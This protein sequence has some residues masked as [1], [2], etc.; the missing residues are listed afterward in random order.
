MIKVTRTSP[1]QDEYYLAPDAYDQEMCWHGQTISALG[2]EAGENVDP[3][4]F[5]AVYAGIHPDTGEQLIPDG[6]QSDYRGH[7]SGFDLTISPDK[8]VSVVGL[9]LD[10]PEVLDAFRAAVETTIDSAE[11]FAAGRK[12]IYGETEIEQTGNLA[13]VVIVHSTTRPVKTDV[14]VDS[15]E[16]SVDSISSSPPDPQLHAHNNIFNVTQRE[17]GKLV[18]LEPHA[19]FQAQ[20]E[21]DSVFNNQLA[22]NLSDLGYGIEKTESGAARIQGIPTEVLDQFS[23]RRQQILDKVEEMREAGYSIPD[24]SLLQLANLKTRAGKESSTMEDLQA[25]WNDQLQ[26]L[27]Y[28]R[29]QLQQDVMAAGKEQHKQRESEL[30]LSATDYVRFVG[31]QLANDNISFS[32]NEVLKAARESAFSRVGEK[33][34][35]AA[36][37]DLVQRKE[38]AEI[39]T[40]PGDS[41]YTT[42]QMYAKVE[43]VGDFIRQANR[44]VQINK[45]SLGIE[46]DGDL[47]VPGAGDISTDMTPTHL[48][49][50]RR[51]AERDRAI[52]RISYPVAEKTIVVGKIDLENAAK[53]FKKASDREIAQMLIAGDVS[54]DQIFKSTGATFNQIENIRQK[55]Y[56]RAVQ[57]A[58]R[59]LNS[60]INAAK[61][62]LT[63]HQ[64][65]LK[66]AE[67]TL[68]VHEHHSKPNW[69]LGVGPEKTVL[70]GAGY[71]TYKTDKTI[72]L[73]E[74]AG[75]RKISSYTTNGFVFTEKSKT[76]DVS[77]GKTYESKSHGFK[78]KLGSLTLFEMKTQNIKEKDREGNIIHKTTKTIT[79]FGTKY[80][81][82]SIK[83]KDGS[84]TEVKW[85]G[86]EKTDIFGR[87]KLV[88]KQQKSAHQPKRDGIF[89]TIMLA[90]MAESHIPSN[91]KTYQIADQIALAER[92]GRITRFGGKS[93]QAEVMQAIAEKATK[94]DYRSN[95]ILTYSKHRAETLNQ[96]IRNELVQSG[97]L[98]KGITVQVEHDTP[99][100]RVSKIIELAAGDH[101]RLGNKDKELGI[102]GGEVGIVKSIDSNGKLVMSVQNETEHN[103]I[104][105]NINRYKNITHNY[106]STS[107]HSKSNIHNIIVDYDAKY[108]NKNMFA[109]IEQSIKSGQRLYIVSRESDNNMNIIDVAQKYDALN[110]KYK[111]F[112]SLSKDHS[113]LVGKLAVLVQRSDDK[114]V[115]Y[116][117]AKVLDLDIEKSSAKL[118]YTDKRGNSVIRNHSLKDIMVA[119]RKNLIIPDAKKIEATIFK[120][121]IFDRKNGIGKSIQDKN[122]E[123]S[124]DLALS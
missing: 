43:H 20:K 112:L 106:A 10:Q 102:R 50:I 27:G 44:Q 1:S 89:K 18:A 8:S 123:K 7:R 111:Q 86:Y 107:N 63:G 124:P 81:K 11:R 66:G 16:I 118:E 113:G 104:T 24:T 4:H 83:N 74:N 46:T 109:N 110:A 84:F 14:S 88:I 3:V 32:R 116:K 6:G 100:G 45:S 96:Y 29:E 36:F 48:V 28:S 77:T 58:E 57:A 68:D 65:K 21:L 85:R 92:D 33:E 79:L 61:N 54:D 75:D 39:A 26:D 90:L 35:V 99:T 70:H 94:G 37:D 73:G 69:K 62:N 31:Q 97:K 120:G 117:R 71:R 19:L 23:K 95:H 93:N 119:D 59:V 40:T 25:G 41:L 103:D 98:E 9:V 76:T 2:I 51:D 34:L 78:H 38:F 17:D 87:K 15:P 56:G 12:T 47:V 55:V 52:E 49:G 22:V 13:A 82:T 108:Y 67:E 115:D 72:L 105:L 5:R 80:G 60:E 53:H 101:I 64:L 121:S 30:S 114:I 42:K 122:I 91:T